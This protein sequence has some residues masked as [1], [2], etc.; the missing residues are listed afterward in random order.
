MKEKKFRNEG[1]PKKVLVQCFGKNDSTYD[2][3]IVTEK[4]SETS[5]K[6]KTGIISYNL[7]AAV[8][9][10]VGCLETIR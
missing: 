9:E 10:V 5:L 4:A 6:G 7:V 1:I 3:Y 2:R 8:D